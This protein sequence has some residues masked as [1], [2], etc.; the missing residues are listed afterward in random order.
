MRAPT[1]VGR[2]R[3][4]FSPVYG[5]LGPAVE[6]PR[7]PLPLPTCRCGTYGLNVS[8]YGRANYSWAT[9]TPSDKGALQCKE[10]QTHAATGA[11]QSVEMKAGT[12]RALDSFQSL[13]LLSGPVPSQA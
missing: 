3:R 9:S 4:D 10:A 5:N 2:V 6:E 7:D 12:Y 8:R 13:H 1:P 11:G